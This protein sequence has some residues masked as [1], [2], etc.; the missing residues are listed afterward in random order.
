MPVPRAARRLYPGNAKSPVAVGTGNGV[1]VTFDL[2]TPNVVTC[3]VMVD[4]LVQPAAAWVYS[5]G[6]GTLG[7][8]QLV[9]DADFI[10]AS[11]AVIEVFT[12]S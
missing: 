8:D 9:F 12:L 11:G 6:T 10:P 3:M 7:R 2:P 4:G 5:R 1:L